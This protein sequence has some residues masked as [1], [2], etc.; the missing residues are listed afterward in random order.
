VRPVPKFGRSRPSTEGDDLQQNVSNRRP[1]VQGACL[2]LLKQAIRAF[3]R[4]VS[5]DTGMLA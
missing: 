5:Q 4:H 3:R 1:T 2:D